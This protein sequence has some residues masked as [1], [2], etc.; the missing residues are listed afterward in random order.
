MRYV[1]YTDGNHVNNYGIILDDEPDL[2]Y[3]FHLA[4]QM[5]DHDFPWTAVDMAFTFLMDHDYKTIRNKIKDH[6]RCV[7]LKN[8]TLTSPFPRPRHDVICVGLNYKDHVNECN[9]DPNFV[10]PD[11]PT[12]FCKRACHIFGD[13]DDLENWNLFDTKVD[14]EVELA[15][16]IG[17]RGKN[18][19]PSEVKDYIL[20]YSVFNDLSARTIQKSTSQWYRGKSLDGLCVMGPS[21][22]LAK[23]MPYPPAFPIKS[24]VN[25]ELRQS[26][27]TDNLTHSIDKLISQF[28]EGCTLEPG[29]IFITGTPAGVGMGMD[30]PQFLK[31]GDSITCEIEGVGSITNKIV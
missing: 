28:S 9:K 6:D 21:I 17:R 10:V 27:T 11:E 18:I 14:Y 4:D 13:G 2:I 31:V 22:L 30:P 24:Y 15:V 29:D 23:D 20:G 7:Q 8:Y 19:A 26:S 1:H 3:E 25:G 12:Y 5:H 16:V